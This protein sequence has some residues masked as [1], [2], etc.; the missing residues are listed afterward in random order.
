MI[1]FLYNKDKELDIYDKVI[2][3][4]KSKEVSELIYNEIV[5]APIEIDKNE[6]VQQLILVI[7]KQWKD[8]ENDFYER[9]GAF[10]GGHISEPDIICFLTRFDKFPYYYSTNA[11]KKWFSAPLFANPT[12]RIRVIMHELCHFFQPVDLPQDIKEAIPV[13]LNDHN[14]FKMYGLDRG[15]DSKEEQ[16]WRKIIWDIYQKGGTFRDVLEEIKKNRM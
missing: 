8:L 11:Q 5:S 3:V 12:E 7:N 13:I 15:H 1:K 4:E 2:K 10:Y 14:S 9:L 6:F 16:K